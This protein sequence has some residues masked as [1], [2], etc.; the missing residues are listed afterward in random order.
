MKT[1]HNACVNF[2]NFIRPRAVLFYPVIAII[3]FF[4]LHYLGYLDIHWY[5][6]K[7]EVLSLA[8]ISGV[9]AGFMLTGLG[10][11]LTLPENKFTV[12]IHKSGHLACVIKVL[13][14]GFILSTLSTVLGVFHALPLVQ[15]IL[16]VASCAEMILGAKNIFLITRYA[17]KSL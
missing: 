4:C 12:Y 13:F 16:F 6:S 14:V 8:S 15:V 11:L 2:S 1:V 7:K 9:F 17:N 10:L 3:L 5:T